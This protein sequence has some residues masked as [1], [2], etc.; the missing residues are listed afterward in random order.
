[1]YENILRDIGLTD[2]EIKVYIALMKL[3]PT[4]TGPLITSSEVSSSKVY[5]ILDRLEKKGLVGHFIKENVKVY[6]AQDPKRLLEYLEDKENHILNKKQ[7]FKLLMP[8]FENMYARTKEKTEVTIFDGF[9]A[10]TSQVR[11]I[12]SELKSGDT[13]YILNA[14]Y[15]HVP[16]LRSFFR[17]H[18]KMRADKGIY[19]MMLANYDV[20]D[21]MED[22][23]FLNAEVRF[24]PQY[25]HSL[26]EIIFYKNKTFF[27]VWTEIPKG[28]LIESKEA[29]DS[30]RAYF[31]AFWKIAEPHQ[32]K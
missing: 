9:K 30:F 10:V 24:L 3:G 15:G 7:E 6:H 26:T 2:G 17:N 28:F 21:S 31:N 22:T 23:T 12:L 16:G 29:T 13:Y 8:E 14:G 19:L 27:C 1:M 5:K 4:R 32:L 18:N 11:S 20:R 25:L